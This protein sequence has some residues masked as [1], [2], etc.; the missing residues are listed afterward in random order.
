VKDSSAQ[1]YY[2]QA[3]QQHGPVGLAEL[4]SLAQ[5]GQL[6]PRHDMVWTQGMKDWQPAGEVDGVF[7]KR[8]VETPAPAAAAPAITNPDPY[9]PPAEIGVD[10]AA[11]QGAT[12]PGARRRSFLLVTYF[13]PFLL[14]IPL[15]LMA[16]II[17]QSSNPA[18]FGMA[19]LFVLIVLFVTVV[20]FGVQRLA[21]VGMSRWWYLGNLVPILQLWVGYRMFACPA[22][23]A[24]HKKLDGAGIALAIL[25]WGMLVLSLLVAVGV[26]L[27]IGG[28]MGSPEL[29]REIEQFIRELEQSSSR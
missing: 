7:E 5:S 23:Y 4:K 8:V 24:Y 15:G 10:A 14:L 6:N 29:Q 17:E 3:G 28:A 25:Y 1:W 13:L 9:A 11:L 22:G 27:I 16:P 18:P 12:W 20:W 2:S 26:M 21:N 19:I